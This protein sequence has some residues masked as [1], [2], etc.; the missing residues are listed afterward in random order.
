[1]DP[2][3][4]YDALERSDLCQQRIPSIGQ[5]A[6]WQRRF[7]LVIELSLDLVELTRRELGDESLTYGFEVL[8]L[9]V[10]GEGNCYQNSE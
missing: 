6:D 10:R 7:H 3:S 9:Q 2:L 8:G 4:R 5:F 1:M